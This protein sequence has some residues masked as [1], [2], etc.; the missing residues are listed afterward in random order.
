MCINTHINTCVRTY[1][2]TCSPLLTNT[3]AWCWRFLSPGLRF[4]KK[5]VFF[6]LLL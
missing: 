6:T 5:Y 3:P 4:G 1:T 2:F